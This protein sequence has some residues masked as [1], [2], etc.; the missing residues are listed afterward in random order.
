MP[1]KYNIKQQFK[2]EQTAVCCGIDESHR[3]GVDF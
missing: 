3:F 2:K 1:T